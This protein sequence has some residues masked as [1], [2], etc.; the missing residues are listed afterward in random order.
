MEIERNLTYMQQREDNKIMYPSYRIGIDST[1]CVPIGWSKESTIRKCEDKKLR[2]F[3]IVDTVMR[4][5]TWKEV[6]EKQLYEK[7]MVFTE[8]EL[9]QMDWTVVYQ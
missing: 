7:K 4:D 5:N 9:I 2:Y 1:G 8:E 6:C 3:F